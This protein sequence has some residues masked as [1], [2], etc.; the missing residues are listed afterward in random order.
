MKY[1]NKLYVGLVVFGAGMSN[2]MYF[3]SFNM[4]TI[5]VYFHA[6][7]HIFHHFTYYISI[8]I[9]DIS[10][11]FSCNSACAD[12]SSLHCIHDSK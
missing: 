5:Y 9:F 3:I 7:L 4:C 2:I 11:L 12:V 8:Y 6:P 10:Y 1:I